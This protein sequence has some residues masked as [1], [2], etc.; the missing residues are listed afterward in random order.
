SIDV[1]GLYT[2]PAIDASASIS[3]SV[4]GQTPAG[5]ANVTVTRAAPTIVT[6]ASATLNLAGTGAQ[7]DVLGDGEAGEAALVYTWSATLA[8]SGGAAT[9][10]ANNGTNSG[11][12]ATVAFTRAGTYR[13]L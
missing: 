13:L 8:P 6:A 2:A 3:A 10:S 4:A 7:L 9:F 11:K 1:S 5:T 12:G